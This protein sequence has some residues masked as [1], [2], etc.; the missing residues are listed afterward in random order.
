MSVRIG[1]VVAFALSM[2]VTGCAEDEICAE[3]VCETDT[4]CLEI[5]EEFCDGAVVGAFCGF[6]D[7]CTCECEFGCLI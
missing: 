2:F 1:L 5:C 6:G 4:E 7:I 3:G